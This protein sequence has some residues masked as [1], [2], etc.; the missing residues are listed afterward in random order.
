MGNTTSSITIILVAFTANVF[1]TIMKFIVSI[2]TGSS[3]MIA[4]TIHSFADSFNQVF[5]LTGIKK[6]K[7]E[8]DD[9][10]PFGYSGELYFW[11]FIVA[12]IL[13][14]A[15]SVFSIYE[16]FHKLMHPMP[17][18]NVKYAFIVLGLSI[19]AEGIAF[20][21]AF[22]KVNKERK[23]LSIYK[24]LRKTKKSELLVI[25]L[26]DLAAITGLS[27]AIIALFLQYKTNILIFDGIASIII[28][29]ILAIVAVFL[30]YETKSL[31][32][33]ESADPELIKRIVKIFIDDESV[34]SLINIRSLQFGPN[35]IMLAAKVEFDSHLNV[36]EVSNLINGI[37]K[38]IRKKFPDI[39]KIF[40]EPDIF[41]ENH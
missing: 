21:K 9:L 25:F 28:G 20:L 38:D 36:V 23:E 2:I 37:E 22:K 39:K 27:V 13:F 18:K 26:E 40:I 19:I 6:G 31:L 15:G 4:E 32:V 33:G 1:I 29:L 16:G 14:S 12:I 7:K 8:A 11:S 30:G 41:N 3:A 10:H 34:V 24:Y 5:L 17:L 35:D